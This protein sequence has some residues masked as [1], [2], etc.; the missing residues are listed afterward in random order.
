[1][2]RIKVT[3]KNFGQV[4]AMTVVIVS[5]LTV[6]CEEKSDHPL[7]NQQ[8]NTIVVDGM[9]TN[10]LK[11]QEIRLSKPYSD[12]NQNPEPVTGAVVTVIVDGLTVPFIE[13]T[14]EPGL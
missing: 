5:L 1:M 10:E 6:S 14:E 12:P 4:I 3:Y 13:S 2:S 9:L 7:P 11:R 8:I